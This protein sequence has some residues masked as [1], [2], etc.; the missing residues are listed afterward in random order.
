M[1]DKIESKESQTKVAVISIVLTFIMT[2][3]GSY[4]TYTFID[5]RKEHDNFVFENRKELFDESEVNLKNIKKS[6]SNLILLFADEYVIT[7]DKLSKIHSEFQ[8]SIQSY[9]EYLVK[10]Q[11]LGDSNQIIAA[12][13]I[14]NWV[15]R[16]YVEV[17]LQLKMAKSAVE[18]A[19]SFLFIKE[20]ESDHFKF[21]KKALSSE[22]ENLVRNENRLFYTLQNYNRPVINKLELY[23]TWQFRQSLGLEATPDIIKAV[24]E[25]PSASERS[26]KH[27]YIEKARPFVIAE[28][29]EFLSEDFTS[30]GDDEFQN[31]KNDYYHEASVLK[32]ISFAIENNSSLQEEL[33]RRKEKAEKQG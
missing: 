8:D 6:Y 15:W 2:A 7:P 22:I 13:N 20:I 26:N 1:T 16:D 3:I 18:Q 24:S 28:M 33:K 25:L 19:E 14:L 21:E 4:F 30:S 29:R 27:E 31:K 32:F 17:D 9:Q 23:L 12:K 5:S 11:R 10:L